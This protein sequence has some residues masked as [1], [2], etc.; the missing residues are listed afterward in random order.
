M[1][2]DLAPVPGL[3]LQEELIGR[4][5]EQAL[6]ERI[7][8]EQLMPFQF[9]GFEGKRLTRSFGW[10][11][12]FAAQRMS[13]TEPLPAWLLPVRERCARFAALPADALEQALLI[14]YDPGAG[15]GWH[16]DRPVFEQVVG[17]SLGAPATLDFRRRLGERRF[18]RVPVIL[19][20]RSAYLLSGPARHEWE[21]GIG[22]HAALRFSITFRVL[23]H[24]R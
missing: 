9:Q 20:P 2:F 11:Y 22:R 21:H 15:I 12:D 19:P 16:R 8:A 6:I 23:R 1:L 17:L 7:G 24:N 4:E 13:P 18:A 5:E 10:H 3:K 14:R